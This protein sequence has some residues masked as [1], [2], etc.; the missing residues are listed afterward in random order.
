MHGFQI[1]DASAREWLA[2]SERDWTPDFFSAANFSS[3]EMAQRIADREGGE[4][5][6][7]IL[8]VH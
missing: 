6:L 4:R 5:T 7:Y 1:F 2:D 3:L 8:Q